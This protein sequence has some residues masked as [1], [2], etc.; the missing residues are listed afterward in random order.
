MW[1]YRRLQFLIVSFLFLA[2]GCMHSRPEADEVSEVK[3]PVTIT[4]VAI[5]TMS[6]S[7]ELSGITSFLK[8]NTVKST[9]NGIVESLG[10]DLGSSVKK[11]EVLLTLK[12]KEAAAL[13]HNPAAD[14]GFMFSGLIT[15]K[16]SKDGIVSA[17]SH[18][19]GDYVQEGDEVVV[20]SEQSSLAFLLEVPFELH[21]YIHLGANCDVVLSDG[22]LIK[23]SISSN[24]PI[25]DM[26]SQTENF[27]VKPLT[28]ERLPENLI[29]KVYIIRSVKPKAVILPK[30]ALLSNE[31]QTEFWVMKLLNDSMAVKIPVQ[32]GIE[33]IENVEILSPTFTPAD[34][35]VLTG[36]Y[37]L[38]D[39]A[40]VIIQK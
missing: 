30:E 20:I 27:I 26:Q 11:G 25:M 38:A 32:K 18:H 4:H 16:A 40:K 7:M 28:N 13:E 19:K 9:A 17:I 39:T 15:I 6:E 34:R 37:G 12:T 36:N 1:V 3:T 23:G 2:F 10:V 24:L 5:G 29:V 31:L 35:I 8:K 14:S 21:S 33:N 22:R